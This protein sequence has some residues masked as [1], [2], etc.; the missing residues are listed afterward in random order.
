MQARHEAADALGGGVGCEGTVGDAEGA[1]LSESEGAAEDHGG[2]MEIDFVGGTE[3][4]EAGR[5]GGDYF[6]NVR[7]LEATACGKGTPQSDG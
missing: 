7:G 1:S 4:A 2:G 6:A 3:V 5:S